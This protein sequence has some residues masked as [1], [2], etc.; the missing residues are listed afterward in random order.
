MGKLLSK[1]IILVLSLV[2]FFTLALPIV[3]EKTIESVCNKALSK[4][5][6][7]IKIE[8]PK[9]NVYLIPKAKFLAK[10]VCIKKA[11]DITK[12]EFNNI[13]FDLRLLPLLSRKIHFN[14]IEIED[15]VFDIK[16]A[17]KIQFNTE[18]FNEI[19]KFGVICD[20]ADIKKYKIRNNFVYK[21]HI[22]NYTLIKEMLI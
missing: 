16:L 13:S 4:S 11:D 22:M 15:F 14:K 20:N 2:V 6:Y 10:R 9:L 5:N 19:E 3:F 7:S 8:A 21:M 17:K 18:F 1:Y 12:Y